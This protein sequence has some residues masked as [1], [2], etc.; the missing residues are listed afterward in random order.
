MSVHVSL[1]PQETQL[2]LE[3]INRYKAEKKQLS[4]A[5]KRDLENIKYKINI[6]TG[7]KPKSSW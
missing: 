6:Q 5:Y 3:A 1:T 4:D 7:R 2:I